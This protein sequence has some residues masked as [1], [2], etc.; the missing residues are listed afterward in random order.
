MISTY[1]YHAASFFAYIVILLCWLIPKKL[2]IKGSIVFIAMLVITG[3]IVALDGFLDII[4]INDLFSNFAKELLMKIYLSFLV[5]ATYMEFA[6]LVNKAVNSNLKYIIAK[7]SI[8][9]PILD[10]IL[11]FIF[12]ID[13]VLLA[14]GGVDVTGNSLYA[15]YGCAIIYLLLILVILFFEKTSV[16]K[17]Y[18]ICFITS[19]VVWTIAASMQYFL[20]TM[21]HMPVALVCSLA[22]IFLFIENPTNYINMEYNCFKNNYLFSYLDKLCKNGTK[23]V[24]ILLNVESVNKTSSF[25]EKVEKLKKDIIKKCS[26]HNYLKVFINELGMIAFVSRNY[27]KADEYFDEINGYINEFIS[28][29]DNGSEYRFRTVGCRNVHMF[30]HADELILMVGRL[31]DDLTM[32][33]DNNIYREIVEKE[34]LAEREEI[35]VRN[36]IFKAL[37]EDRLEA[38]VQPIY[39]TEHKRVISAEALARIR[40]TDGSLMLPYQFIPVSEKTGLDIPLGY[41]MI[42]KICQLLSDP[43][44]GKL[45]QY[46]DINLSISQC[47]QPDM[48]SKIIGIVQKYNLA[49]NRI[50]FE[51]TESGF[52]DKMEIINRNVKLLT[53][54]GFGFSLDDFGSGESNLDYLVKMPVDYLKLDMH[55]IWAYFENERAKKTVK[56]IIKISHEMGLKVIAEG[57]ETKEQLDELV[58]QK[59]DFVQGYYFYKPMAVDEYAK[60]AKDKE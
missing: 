55:M 51:I 50:N 56:T 11:I 35:T 37:D 54:Y 5:I 58:E 44:K 32:K 45:F 1:A 25:D 40:K 49:S 59:V 8:I 20:N 3:L 14:N 30:K 33:A 34:I 60:I 23:G 24:Y 10:V 12:N 6:Y 4:F 28:I 9:S 29:G 22:A 57:V 13:I 15:A 52:V 17:W 31:M 43:V 27:S 42:E 53:S 39:S 26:N 21:G 16:N 18:R 19:A 48:A 2:D 47:E 36:E 38:F 7:Y 41:R 46:V